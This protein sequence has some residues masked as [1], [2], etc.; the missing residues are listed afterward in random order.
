[1]LVSVT[2]STTLCYVLVDLKMTRLNWSKHVVI[3]EQQL[4]KIIRV[5]LYV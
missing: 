5:T 3:L 4:L 1:V 2:D